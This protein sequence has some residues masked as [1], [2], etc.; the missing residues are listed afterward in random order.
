MTLRKNQHRKNKEEE[1]TQTVVSRKQ[2]EKEREALGTGMCLFRSHPQGELLTD[3]LGHGLI[4][5]E[6]AGDCSIPV[7]QSFPDRR[8]LECHPGS[9][10]C[11]NGLKGALETIKQAD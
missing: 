9:N 8:A 2:R 11:I 7:T 6:P 3:M 5:D 4:V 10:T 1:D